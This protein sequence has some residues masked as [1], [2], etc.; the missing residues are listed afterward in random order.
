MVQVQSR[1]KVADNTGAH[2]VGIIKILGNSRP[3]YARIGQIVKVSVKKSAPSGTA[4]LH[5]MFLAVIVRT[6]KAIK[7]ENGSCIS[8]SDNACVLVKESKTGYDM[9]G[10]RVFGPVARELREKGFMKIVSLASEV[11]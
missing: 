9:I 11:V 8:F 3:H 4:K 7:R 10:T 5:Q 6:R 2:E 1:L